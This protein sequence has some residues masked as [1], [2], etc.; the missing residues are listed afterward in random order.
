MAEVLKSRLLTYGRGSKPM[1]SHFGLGEF[2]THF[3]T[4]FSGWIGMFT[5]GM[6]FGPMAIWVWVNVT[7]QETD[8]PLG[9]LASQLWSGGRFLGHSESAKKKPGQCHFSCGDARL[10]FKCQGRKYAMQASL[11]WF[12]PA[13]FVVFLCLSLSLS[14]AVFFRFLALSFVNVDDNLVTV[15]QI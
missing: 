4:Y 13:V 2:T 5:G 12:Q 3:R 8:R 10:S 15:F 9:L 11:I 14:L 7:S 6:G 1:G